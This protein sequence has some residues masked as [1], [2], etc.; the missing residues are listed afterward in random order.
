[1]RFLTPWGDQSDFYKDCLRV[2]EVL[3]QGTGNNSFRRLK[4]EDRLDEKIF[5][6]ITCPSIPNVGIKQCFE[7]FTRQSL[8]PNE[9]DG[10]VSF[11]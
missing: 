2:E 10:Q 8:K 7:S 5:A 11:G 6:S 4:P 3:K 1:M 9:D